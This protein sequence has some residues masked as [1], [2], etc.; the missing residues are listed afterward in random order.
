MKRVSEDAYCLVKQSFSAVCQSEKVLSPSTV[1][2]MF[3]IAL[4]LFCLSSSGD[5]DGTVHSILCIPEKCGCQGVL[6]VQRR[7]CRLQT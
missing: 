2:T 5:T 4:P 6:L 3:C 1:L 7:R